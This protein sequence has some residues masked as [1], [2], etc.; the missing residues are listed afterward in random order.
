MDV[1]SGSPRPRRR[2]GWWV[3]LALVV[4]IALAILGHAY[5]GSYQ[6][7]ELEREVAELRAAGEPMVAGDFVRQPVAEA[8]NAALLLRKAAQSINDTSE[9]WGR[10]HEL[11]L[12]SGLKDDDVALV[13]EVVE[14]NQFALKLLR[15]AR[16]R[17]Q[18]D[19]QIPISTLMISTR[20]PDVGG[21]TN[22]ASL[23]RMSALLAHQRRDD[24]EAVERVRDLLMQSKAVGK[25]D[26]GMIPLLLE[27]SSS[28]MAARAA[29]EMTRNLWVGT[30]A[31]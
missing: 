26:T 20:L 31:G 2:W 11:Q 28:S 24:A 17:K 27:S 7:R 16:G 5:W 12:D 22:L 3:A 14:Q 10:A 13:G 29:I 9:A 25:M 19:W 6:E 18:V 1:D 4:F 8:D 23:S 21:Q 15:E 30:N